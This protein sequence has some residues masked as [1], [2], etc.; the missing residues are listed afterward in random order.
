MQTAIFLLVELVLESGHRILVN[1]P[2]ISV[3]H[4][5]DGDARRAQ[6]GHLRRGVLVGTARDAL[7]SGAQCHLLTVGDD[8]CLFLDGAGT[9]VMGPHIAQRAT[10][11]IAIVTVHGPADRQSVKR[12]QRVVELPTPHHQRHRCAVTLDVGEGNGLGGN[13]HHRHASQHR[14][15]YGQ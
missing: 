1:K 2:N 6:G 9:C 13:R 8:K 4:Q 15:R 12:H 7:G 14:H 11:H 3:V 5:N 10:G